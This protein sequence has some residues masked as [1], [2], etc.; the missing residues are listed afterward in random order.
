MQ[1]ASHS[2][3]T[4]FSA[5]QPSTPCRPHPVSPPARLHP[6]S[7]SNRHSFHSVISY[8]ATPQMTLYGATQ[9]PYGPVSQDIYGGHHSLYSTSVHRL[10]QTKLTWQDSGMMQSYSRPVSKPPA[11]NTSPHMPPP[12]MKSSRAVSIS[13]PH[14]PAPCHFRQLPIGSSHTSSL[15]TWYQTQ[16]PSLGALSSPRNTPSPLAVISC[17]PVN[18]QSI[19]H[20]SSGHSS[21]HLI[22]H[23]QLQNATPP[24][25]KVGCST[26][27][28]Q[29]VCNKSI[30]RVI[31]SNPLQ[32]LQKRVILNNKFVGSS[33]I[34]A[35]HKMANNQSTISVPSRSGSY[36][37]SVEQLAGCEPG[38]QFSTYYNLDQNRL[39]TPSHLVSSSYVPLRLRTVS[40]VYQQTLIESLNPDN[41]SLETSINGVSQSTSSN[42]SHPPRH[43]SLSSSENENRQY[44]KNDQG[45]IDCENTAPLEYQGNSCLYCEKNEYSDTE[46]TFNSENQ[47][48]NKQ[49]CGK[50]V[51][52]EMTSL[53][54][55]QNMDDRLFESLQEKEN[56]TF[57][58]D[59]FG[60]GEMEISVDDLKQLYP[61]PT[62]PG[63]NKTF[64]I[65]DSHCDSSGKHQ[66]HGNE[67]VMGLHV[68]QSPRRQSRTE[69]LNKYVLDYHNGTTKQSSSSKSTGKGR[70]RGC[71]K[72]S[73]GG[74]NADSFVSDSIYGLY[75]TASLNV[76]NR[77]AEMWHTQIQ[78]SYPTSVCHTR[79]AD[80]HSCDSPITSDDSHGVHSAV[81]Y[82][83]SNTATSHL[84]VPHFPST[85]IA[86]LSQDHSLLFPPKKKRGRPIG[87]KN[88]PKPSGTEVKRKPKPMKKT[89]IYLPEMK[90]DTKTKARTF[91]GPYIHIMGTKERPLSVEVVNILLGK[92][93]KQVKNI[94]QKRQVLYDNIRK[95]LLFGHI[96]NLSPMY[97]STKKNK[98]WVCVL[99]FKGS[100]RRELGDLFG[101]YYLNSCQIQSNNEV[102]TSGT[103]TMTSVNPD[104]QDDVETKAVLTQSVRGKHK[105]SEQVELSR[106][107]ISKKSNFLEK[108]EECNFSL[109]HAV[110]PPCTTQEIWIHEVCAVWSRGVYLINHRIYGLKEA[111]QEASE[112]ICIKCQMTGATLGCLN[113]DCPEQYH[114]ICATD[115]EGL[116]LLHVFQMTLINPG[117]QLMP[118]VFKW[119]EIG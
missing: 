71:G 67:D 68:N 82:R 39:S 63:W 45:L 3:T 95:K 83:H 19:S 99:C 13:G 57:R 2:Q 85:P 109:H 76:E 66:F 4:D 61:L 119:V 34:R 64:D 47:C 52:S 17:S 12:S 116:Q 26:T 80:F 101:P 98:T 105:C 72:K 75:Q 51:K 5:Y 70:G 25:P 65:Y 53:G 86:S 49:G 94:K 81:L 100:H 102:S 37:S 32:S 50:N 7:G 106:T 31:S 78:Q 84:F 114:F 24:P 77:P 16:I 42:G 90:L 33:I 55:K 36:F 21:H 59:E 54:P 87:S 15:H 89:E 27:N 73:S 56:I 62:C 60:N 35:S 117:L 11:M 96:S 113:R 40:P 97:D 14:L 112:T 30:K 110:N 28:E 115:T 20:S 79:E 48:F 9:I 46:L 1:M 108:P 22:S 8:G 103:L 69:S 118:N 38:L 91:N 88:K 18:D 23:L 74:G 92:E 44:N 10:Q 107:D 41:S 111:I 43:V 58:E 104:T 29:S 6:H 93:M